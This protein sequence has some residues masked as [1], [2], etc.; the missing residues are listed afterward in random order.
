MLVKLTVCFTMESN[1]TANEIVNNPDFFTD[2]GRI[3]IDHTCLTVDEND[4]SFYKFN[5]IKVED[6]E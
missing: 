2:D 1:Y 4:D 5:L 6:M 3:S